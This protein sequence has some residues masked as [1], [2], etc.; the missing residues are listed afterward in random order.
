MV[1]SEIYYPECWKITS[2][3]NW[4]IYPVNSILRGIKIPSG[5]HHIVMEFI[6]DDIRWGTIM[7]WSST[8]VLILLLLSGLI[9]KSK[10][11]ESFTKTI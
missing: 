9:K 3:P 6:P 8:I 5:K 4:A 2:H 11:D 10:D 7:T 1:L